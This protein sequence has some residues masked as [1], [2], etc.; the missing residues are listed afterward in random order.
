[1]PPRPVAGQTGGAP[2]AAATDVPRTV[3]AGVFTSAQAAR[4]EQ[5]FQRNC[6]SCHVPTQFSGEVFQIVWKD[7]P[8][9]ELYEV[10][11][12]TM[13][14]GAPG[15]LSPGEYTGIISDITS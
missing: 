12:E 14:E 5:T 4:G 1:M 10:M 8:V 6:S 13:P 15:S 7:R 11:S 9:G 3:L 2:A